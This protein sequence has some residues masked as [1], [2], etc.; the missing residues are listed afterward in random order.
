MITYE[1]FSPDYISFFGKVEDNRLIPYGDFIEVNFT[2]SDK[3]KLMKEYKINFYYKTCNIFDCY[4]YK[5]IFY[6]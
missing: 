4:L 1:I 3:S 5:F 6:G 2:D